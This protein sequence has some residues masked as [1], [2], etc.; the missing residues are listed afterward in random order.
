MSKFER[1]AC[2][3]CGALLKHTFVDLGTMPPANSY[4]VDLDTIDD[5]RSYPLRTKVCHACFLVQ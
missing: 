2:R 4:V 3:S 5:E 1:H